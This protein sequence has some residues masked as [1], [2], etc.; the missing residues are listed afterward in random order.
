M[1]SNLKFKL[2][3]DIAIV[4]LIMTIVT[5]LLGVYEA[6]SIN[7]QKEA[8]L[9]NYRQVLFADY[10]ASIKKQVQTVINQISAYYERSQQGLM[11]EEEAK[12]LALNI[13]RDARYGDDK[14][15]VFWADTFTGIFLASSAGNAVEGKLRIE[16]K[17]AKGND[18]VKT[19]IENAKKPEGGYSE[20]YYPRPKDVDPTQT[21]LPKRSYSAGFAPWQWSIGTGN[22]VDDLEKMVEVY[23][24]Q[25]DEEQARQL[26]F[27]I[28][29]YLFIL[30]LA[31]VTSLFLN[32]KIT[33]RIKPMAQIAQEVTRGNLNV[34]QIDVI[35][36]DSIGDLAQAFNGMVQNLSAL[37]K[38]TKDYAGQVAQTADQLHKGM[39]QSAQTSDL[40]VRSI[41]SV[42][43]GAFR[44]MSLA[45][46]ASVAVHEASAAMATMITNS[47]IMADKSTEVAQAAQV[48]EMN[49]KQTISQM[50]QIERT[51]INSADVVK[52]LGQRSQQI[53]VMAESISKIASQ[54]N[55]LALNAAIEAA[56]AGEQGRGFAVVADEVRQLAEQANDASKQITDLI[57]VIHID[58]QKAIEAMD[59]G[60]NEVQTGTKVVQHAGQS[61]KEISLLV[62]TMLEEINKTI[63]QMQDTANA[64]QN[65][66][67]T[68]QEVEGISKNISLETAQISSATEEQSAS[69]Q[70]ITASSIALAGMAD[71]L[72]KWVERFKL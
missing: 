27:S 9:E 64:S 42:D 63:A 1:F 71:E 45:K 66:E 18:F 61:F 6:Y 56:R 51:V 55:L 11:T 68:V 37:V 59:V 5:T 24:A 7:Q 39:E 22:Y 16:A 50:S 14:S 52:N 33:K 54:T 17:D 65:A 49:I 10:D 19:F 72:N 44:Q 25:L 12:K 32:S 29:T 13:V 26:I 31:I 62:T 53:S 3:R 8:R 43:N 40:I 70:E 67:K 46:D 15:G 20:Y 34:R 41:G 4:I 38:Q 2:N 47:K 69:I 58:A 36:K 21:P 23:K 28:S 48:G 57:S 60:T 30:A 35:A